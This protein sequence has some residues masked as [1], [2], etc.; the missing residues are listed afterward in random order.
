MKQFVRP[1]IA[2]MAGYIPGEQPQDGEYI[3][4]NTN[5]N[6]YPAS[7][8]IRAAVDAVLSRGLQKY[9]DAVAWNF[10]RQA[11][12]VLG[13]PPEWILC[14]N[15]SDD[16]LT[17]LTRTFVGPN[18][19]LRLP[20][21]SYIL[22]RSLA[23]LQGAVAEEIPFT[24]NW[25]LPAAFYASRTAAPHAERPVKLAFLPNPNSP[26]GT[27]IPTSEMA[28]LV[29]RMPC[30]LVIDEAY[31]DFV[32]NSEDENATN[33][34]ELVKRSEKAIVSRTLSKSYALAGLRFGFCVAQPSVIEQLMKVKDSYN[35]DALSI[36]IATAAVGDQAWL[37]ENRRKI[38]A[39]RQRLTD[40]MRQLGFHVIDSQANFTWNTHPTASA[41]FLY[42][43]LKSRK[44]LVR[45]MKYAG[46]GEGLR[47]SVGTDAQIE[48]LLD[49]ISKLVS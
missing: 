24:S 31:A 41:K 42:E 18:D 36:A 20:T 15:G 35:C 16:I 26:T 37:V 7:D 32:E 33:C 9:P 39:T 13:V 19:L 8:A 47:I 30:P 3:K 46:F 34:I 2:A 27:R 48:R 49:E 43:Q 40:G 4:L 6:P 38:L 25:R 12:E 11:G 29:E 21:P 5:E 23:E 10:R 44:I 22:Y 45:Y 14:G 1:E 28:E 17:I